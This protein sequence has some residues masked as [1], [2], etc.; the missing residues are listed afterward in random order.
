MSADENFAPNAAEKM[1]IVQQQPGIWF[2][3]LPPDLRCPPG[4]EFLDAEGEFAKIRN[5][6]TGETLPLSIEP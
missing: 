5:L 3:K 1:R 2:G 6:K 4:F